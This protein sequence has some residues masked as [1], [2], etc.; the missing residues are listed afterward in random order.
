MLK[1]ALI[2]LALLA[3]AI[4]GVL[5][6]AA[7]KPDTSRIAR[8]A[9]IQAAPDRIFALI[10]DLPAWQ[11]WSPY[12]KKDPDMQRSFTGP[13]A[14][15]GAKYAWAGDKNIGDGRMEIVESTAPSK[16]A[17]RLEFLKPFQHTAMADFTLAPAA[18]GATTVTWAMTGPANYL[19]KVMSV[20]FDFDKM[21]G[22]DFEAGL[23][24]LK[25]LAE[26]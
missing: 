3:V 22:R 13:A 15:I 19:S 12:E 25:T 14:G 4:A 17:I 11:T 26:K 23:T 20:V 16:I 9:Q 6:Y 18:N 7:T 2:V 21:I 1:I 8:S 10:N 5:A 24:N